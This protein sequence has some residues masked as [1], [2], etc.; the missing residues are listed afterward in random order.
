MSSSLTKLNIQRQIDFKCFNLFHSSILQDIRDKL[1]TYHPHWF[2]WNCLI[3]LVFWFIMFIIFV[4]IYYLNYVWWLVSDC[5]VLSCQHEVLIEWSQSLSV[6]VWWQQSGW[7]LDILQDKK[8]YLSTASWRLV[9][10]V[11]KWSG[12]IKDG[13]NY[14]QRKW[15]AV[16]NVRSV[17]EMS[18]DIATLTSVSTDPPVL[19]LHN[20]LYNT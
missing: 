8:W 19:A 5:S 6:N 11:V 10:L 9:W 4:N 18:P 3:Y 13:D 14:L 16:I 20:I 7:I 12:A 1:F 2:L 15:F 17:K